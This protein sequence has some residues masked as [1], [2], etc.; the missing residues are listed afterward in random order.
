MDSAT[1]ILNIPPGAPAPEVGA[2]AGK[3]LIIED[4]LIVRRALSR[5]LA[6]DG[7]EVLTAADGNEALLLFDAH[8][9]DIVLSDINLPGASG[10][11][12]LHYCKQKRPSVEVILITGNPSLKDAVSA[13]KEG[14][15]NYLAKPISSE[16]LLKEMKTALLEKRRKGE[17][18]AMAST[19]LLLN[20]P[21]KSYH[22][23]RP[24]GTGSIGTVL[25]VEK[26]GIYFAMKILRF[27]GD[28]IMDPKLVQRFLQEGQLL[29]RLNHPGIVKVVEHGLG[30]DQEMPYIIMEYVA[31]APLSALIAG[32]KLS[33]D[34]K[35]DILS[36]IAL[37][38]AVV[39]NAGILHRDIKPSNILI[40]LDNQVKISDFGIARL[41]GTNLTMPLEVLGSPAYMAPE[42]F[43]G[44]HKI[45]LRA[46]IFSFGVL[47]YELFTGRLPFQAETI[48]A[49]AHIVATEKP[50]APTRLNPQLSMGV[51][52]V[53]GR[54]LQKA[55]EDRY[56][57]AAEIGAALQILRQN[58]NVPVA[59]V[60]Q[61]FSPRHTW[62]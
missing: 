30:L 53:I 9:F 49:M 62:Q 14:A 26:G 11:K 54:M 22:V 28:Q 59:Q 41:G 47:A 52:A 56:Q 37:T 55:P 27:T 58:P 17:E 48:P 1:Q 40:S 50:M 42:S 39:H 57:T 8:H 35:L 10:M 29:A 24:L 12:L 46:D 45:D 60:R 16:K 13:V 6:F 44:S 3:V 20:A 51:E 38:L 23:I 21:A 7:F 19:T 2:A 34:E 5:T 25:L 15:F 33:M 32:Q 36:Q 4:D 18:K 31:G 43:N 61:H